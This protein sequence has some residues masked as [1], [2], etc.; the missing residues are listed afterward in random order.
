LPAPSPS[1]ET[2]P[3]TPAVQEAPPPQLRQILSAAQQREYNQAIDRDLAQAKS[4]LAA[5]GGKTLNGEQARVLEQ[6]RTFL[7]Q[8]EEARKDDLATASNL[9]ERARV[10]AQD[11]L[12]SVR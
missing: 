12:K 11:L 1:A 5:L 4:A 9:A 3:A 2:P 6:A 10:L 8:A 7:R